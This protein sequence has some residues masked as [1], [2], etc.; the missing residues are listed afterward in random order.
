MSTFGVVFV[1]VDAGTAAEKI[2]A[3]TFTAITR[4]YLRMMDLSGSARRVLW[5]HRALFRTPVTVVLQAAERKHP[6]PFAALDSAA[7]TLTHDFGARVVIDA[8]NNSLPDA[9]IATKREVLLDVEHMPRSLLEQLPE[10][11]PLHETLKQAGLA[12]AVWACLGGNPADYKGLLGAW[13][14]QPHE[15]IELVVASFVQDLLGKALD[16]VNSAVAANKRV[17]GLYDMFRTCSEVPSSML[18]DMELVRQ[19]P[20]K[21]LRAVRRR[22]EAGRRG[23]GERILIPADSATSLV[24]RH[25]LT[26]TPS[27]EELIAMLRK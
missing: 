19:S 23:S 21:V 25:G 9:A 4:Y 14:R 16:N 13:K 26:G 12:D 3:D 6:E 8:S 2:K 11:A 22:A 1:P 5:W 27:M 10:L 7:R 18:K 15:E 20:D 17:Q 24:L